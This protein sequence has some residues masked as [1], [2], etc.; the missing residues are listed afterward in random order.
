MTTNE[1]LVLASFQ[2][3]ADLS[4]H[5]H[6]FVTMSSDGQ[7]DP[8]GDGGDALGVLHQESA[9]VG[10]AVSVA[11]RGISKVVVGTGGVTAGSPVA[12]DAAAE[13]IDATTGDMTLGTAL[14]TAAAGELARIL[15]HVPS[16]TSA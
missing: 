12:S 8:T 13:A 1:T 5:Q 11:I 7:I 16:H 9:V 2:A 14:E 3:G 10:D 6:H 4:A 15:L